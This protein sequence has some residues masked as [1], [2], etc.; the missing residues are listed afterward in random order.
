M[1]KSLVSALLMTIVAMTLHAQW[2]TDPLVGTLVS[3]SSVANSKT[4]NVA[5]T[6]G[7]GGSFIGWIDTRLGAPNTIYVQRILSNGTKKFSSDV[8]VSNATG[9]QSSAKTN[10]YMI[11]DGAGGVICVWQDARNESTFFPSNDDIY[12]QRIDA[13]GN[14]LWA[15]NGVRLTVSDN[16]VS[17]K[18]APVID[19]VNATEA[20]VVFGDTRNG[21]INLFA[22]KILLSTGASQWANDASISGSVAGTQNQQQVAND[23]TGGLYIVWQDQRAGASSAD[24]YAQHVNNSGGIV[25]GWGANGTVV[26]NGSNIQNEPQLVSLGTSGFI[27][28]WE[29]ARSAA[30]AYDIYAQR[31]DAAGAVQ[32]TAGGVALCTATLIQTNPQIVASG[33]NYIV[34]WSDGRAGA[35]DRDVYAQAVDGSGTTLW[36]ANGVNVSNV[37]GTNQPFTYTANAL[38]I[39][40][41]MASD[42]SSGAVIAWDDARISAANVDVYAQRISST[43]TLLWSPSTGVAVSTATGNQVSPVIVP[44]LNNGVIVSWR[45]GRSGLANSEIFAARVQSSGTLPLRSLTLTATAKTSSVDLKWNTV[46]ESN[47]SFFSVEKSLDGATFSTVGSVNA[48]GSGNNGYVLAD[49]HPAKGTN[50]YRIKSVDVN[51]SYAYSATTA[52]DFSGGLKVSL[53]V[54]PNPVRGLATLQLNNLANGIYVLTVRDLAG[55]VLMRQSLSVAGNYQQTTLFLQGL[56]AGS[57]LVQVEGNKTAFS[58]QIQKE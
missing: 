43:G 29:D 55:R 1:K 51:K 38:A 46:D 48:I 14:V 32:W 54:S 8:V 23:G 19:L 30:G 6:D 26:A 52:I 18:T 7:A 53:V 16:S 27:T 17:G 13:N 57:Y 40:I 28:T 2:S 4:S 44:T 33:S 11:G 22:Q 24:V 58:T 34:A 47:L 10:L 56:A 50:F 39:G 37:S 49:N 21:A 5:V 9:A 20:I 45:D 35:T 12:G 3:T 31:F 15:A 36:T 41:S 42:G 25:T